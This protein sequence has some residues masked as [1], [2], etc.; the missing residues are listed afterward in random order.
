MTGIVLLDESCEAIQKLPND[1]AGALIKALIS[2]DAENL[3]P[4]AD[5]IFPVIK[6]QVERMQARSAKNT[7]NG[8]K[9]GRPKKN[10]TETQLKAKQ[11]PTESQTKA[12]IPN[13]TKTIPNQDETTPEREGI[14]KDE[15]VVEAWGEFVEMR[16]RLRKPMTGNAASRICAKL[17][18]LSGGNSVIAEKILLQSVDNC[19][20]DIFALREE[21]QTSRK[22][23]FS[24]LQFEDFKTL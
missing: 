7:A 9:G 10:Q 16:K 17:E 2:G 21:K 1:D 3:P 19:W 11:N 24:G 18:K 12:P 4:M 8:L 14:F 5:L 22:N 6:G 13:Q 23:Q 15:F 20:Q